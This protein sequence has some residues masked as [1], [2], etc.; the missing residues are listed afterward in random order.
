MGRFHVGNFETQMQVLGR[1][2]CSIFHEPK[3]LEE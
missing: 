3:V 2:R 1:Q